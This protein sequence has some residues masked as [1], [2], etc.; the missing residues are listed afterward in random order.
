MSEVF[1][2]LQFVHDLHINPLAAV[3][4]IA[5]VAAWLE[6][7]LS[8]R[9]VPNFTAVHRGVAATARPGKPRG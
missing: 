6:H 5:V 9:K 4:S 2:V 1:K 7:T 3:I 8:R